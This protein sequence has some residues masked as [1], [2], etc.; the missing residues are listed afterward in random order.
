MI[1]DQ[2]IPQSDTD[3]GEKVIRRI[4]IQIP[5][6]KSPERLDIF[7]T[8]QVAELT[9]SKANE[10][11]SSG[12]VKVNGSI[13]K[14]SQK[15]KP[16]QLIELEVLSR[17]PL[18]LKA[19]NLPLEIVYEDEWLLVI[20]KPAGMVVHPAQGNREGTLVNALLGH[21]ANLVKTDNP[22][23]PGIVHRLDKDTTGIIVICKREP[24]LSRLAMA[25]RKHT[26]ERQY[27][28]I[29]WWPLPKKSGTIDEAIGRDPRD[30]KKFAIQ[31]DGKRSV[32]H[33][34]MLENF[35]FMSYIALKLETGRTHQ[36]RVHTS[37]AGHPIFGDPD[38]AGRNR[39][40]GRLSSAQR[41]L[42]ATYFEI[43]SR[44]MLHARTLG[45]KH[46]ITGQDMLFEAD[47]PADFLWLLD[48]LREARSG[49]R[50]MLM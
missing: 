37:G 44:Q 33:W 23:R 18:E 24:A 46:P 28:A 47:P 12:Y 38:Y 6:G 10:M 20:N 1:P 3:P 43:I 41:K 2:H 27:L 16:G 36:I 32:T 15:V 13:V 11:I 26:I 14:P 48:Q 39:Q 9:R 40:L 29:V 30:R 34:R 50:R 25:F 45:F 4:E 7:L 8:R 22:D 17:P 42:V 49:K 35:D 5:S 19:E 21:Y 31:A